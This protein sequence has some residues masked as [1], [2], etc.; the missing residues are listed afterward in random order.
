[1]IVLGCE[2]GGES[3][4]LGMRSGK[5]SQFRK[6]FGIIGLRSSCRLLMND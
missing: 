5:G 2:V 6:W 4:I 3:R 1:V